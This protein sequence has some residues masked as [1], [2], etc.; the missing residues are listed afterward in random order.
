MLTQ[1][2]LQRHSGKFYGKYSGEVTDNSDSD[3]VGKV[4]VKVPTIFGT[5]PEVVAR[6]C[7]PFGHFFIPAVGAKVWVEFEGGD[8]NY[9]IWVGT[10]YPKDS[11]PKTAAIS[12]PE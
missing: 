12:P 5:D 8:I 11:A 2:N 3:K 9:P 6:P 4:K 10:W 1:P 7:L